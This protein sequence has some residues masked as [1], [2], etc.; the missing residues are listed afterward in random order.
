MWC[1]MQAN[2]QKIYRYINMYSHDVYV[3]DRIDG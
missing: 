2:L 1:L 3:V